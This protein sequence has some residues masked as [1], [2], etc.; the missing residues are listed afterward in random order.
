MHPVSSTMASLYGVCFG[1]GLTTYW[2]V[3][4]LWQGQVVVQ[5]KYGGYWNK[6]RSTADSGGLSIPCM[7]S[8]AN[9]FQPTDRIP[10]HHTLL[11][12][13]GHNRLD[14]DWR[15]A[16]VY[17]RQ[18]ISRIPSGRH[19]RYTRVITIT[20]ISNSNSKNFHLC[21]QGVWHIAH[22]NNQRFMSRWCY[23]RIE[24][25]TKYYAGV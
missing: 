4:Y 9:V 21:T 20:N 14:G 13:T 2:T 11:C 22:K 7:I 23:N 18:R 19:E 25:P 5:N 12:H 1:K 15:Q 6:T 3:P 24:Q 16:R 10:T 8:I 17:P